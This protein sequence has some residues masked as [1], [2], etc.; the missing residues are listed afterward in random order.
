MTQKICKLVGILNVT[1]DSFSDGGE[2]NTYDK[3]LKRAK[4]MIKEGAEIIDIGGEASGI[5]SKDVSVLDEMERV[6]PVIEGLNG[7]DISVDTYKSV[8]A[9]M[10]LEKGVKIINDITALRGDPGM[11]RMVA[12]YDCKIVLMYSKDDTPRTTF[13]RKIYNDIVNDIKKFFIER[14]RYAV[15]NGI[16][17]D[18]IILDPGMGYFLSDDPVPSFEVINR[19]DEFKDLG[20]ELFI[21]P[22]RK[23]FLGGDIK[24]RAIKTLAASSICVYN[25]AD[26][27]R[28]HDIKEHK[29]VILTVSSL[30]KYRK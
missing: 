17:R 11:A 6:L 22:S 5:N 25:G 9:K 21:S 7:I 15:R 23:S 24:G 12:G 26:Y 19:L 27:L 16:K 13:T 2:Y 10:C 30:I 29:D 8:V 3:A 18:N 14:I 28:V 1:P 20:C 4:K